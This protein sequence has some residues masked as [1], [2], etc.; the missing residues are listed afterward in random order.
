MSYTRNISFFYFFSP[1][2]FLCKAHILL[3]DRASFISMCAGKQKSH[4]EGPYMGFNVLLL[5]SCERNKNKILSFPKQ[6]NGPPLNQW[7]PRKTL[8][9]ELLAIWAG[10][11][12]MP[13]Y[14]ISLA[15]HH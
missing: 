11:L 4:F 10:R 3:L 14:A 8:K 6:L 9:T 5:L 2:F 15:N 13:H 7:D 12:D 1:F